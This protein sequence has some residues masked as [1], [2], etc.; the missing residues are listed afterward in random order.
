MTAIRLPSAH[1]L[2]VSVR[3]IICDDDTCPLT[4]AT[5]LELRPAER[6]TSSDLRMSLASH[7]AYA[8]RAKREV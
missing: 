7:V 3:G 2:T 8:R 4:R 6:W 1:R 5:V